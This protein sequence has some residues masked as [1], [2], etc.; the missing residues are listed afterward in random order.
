MGYAGTLN[1]SSSK[2]LVHSVIH[3]SC[4]TEKLLVHSVIHALCHRKGGYN[5]LIG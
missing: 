2:F 5:V 3:A 1:D 4:I